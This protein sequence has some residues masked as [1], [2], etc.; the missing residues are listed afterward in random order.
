MFYL[1][2]E[3]GLLVKSINM[4]ELWEWYYVDYIGLFFDI[5]LFDE[6]IVLVVGFCGNIF[7][8]RNE[9]EWEYV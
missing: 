8:N 3:V 9:G 7:V 4:G 1:V 6:N 2:G 5:K